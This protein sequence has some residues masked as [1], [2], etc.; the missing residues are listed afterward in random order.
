MTLAPKPGDEATAASGLLCVYDP[1]S[2]GLRRAGAW[3]R[4]T[5]VY[6]DDGGTTGE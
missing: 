1:S 4:L 6:E 2:P 5:E 3:N